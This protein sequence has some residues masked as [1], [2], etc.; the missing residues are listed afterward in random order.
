MQKKFLNRKN[1]LNFLICFFPLSFVFGNLIINIEIVLISL[2]GIFIYK[3]NIFFFYNKKI[4]IVLFSFFLLLLISTILY[5]NLNLGSPQVIKSVLFVR[6]FIFFLVIGAVV[7]N[8]DFNFKYFSLTCFFI[9]IFLS[10]DIV[11]QN[12]VGVNLFG[13]DQHINHNSSVFREELIAGGYIQKFCL[14]G[15]ICLT[16]ISNKF[17]RIALYMF[18]SIFILGIGIFFSGNRMPFILFLISIIISLIF[19]KKY[20]T[21]IF[22]SLSSILVFLIILLN[23]NNVIKKKY[24]SF[25][26]NSIY[27]AKILK[28][29]IKNNFRENDILNMPGSGHGVIFSSAL[30][31]W[32]EKPVLGRGIKSFGIT[33]RAN[34]FI[35]IPNKT[36]YGGKKNR[37]CA[38][39]PHNYYLEILNDTGFVGLILLIVFIILISEK[40]INFYRGKNFKY[41][42]INY[43]LILTLLTE[44]IPLRSS[45]S[46]FS[47]ANASFIFFLMGMIVN[48]QKTKDYN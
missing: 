11:F 13:Y 9:T 21:I 17:S 32:L 14:I 30:D 7:N 39:H 19:I 43:I 46:F 36:E 16:F 20:R 26:S 22:I 45:G 10:I 6:Y 1:I 40:N 24:I 42:I 35:F 33:C 29:E 18:F 12:Y 44:F 3:S 27:I 2:L 15:L 25:F 23:N 38:P 31:T 34:Q 47:T 28:N 37:T 5:H 8:Q 41:K 4:I 48:L